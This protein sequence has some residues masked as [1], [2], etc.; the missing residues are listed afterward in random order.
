MI[1]LT[2]VGSV[3]DFIPASRALGIGRRDFRGYDRLTLDVYHQKVGT[4]TISYQL[5]NETA[6]AP[7]LD[8]GGAEVVVSDAQA[9]AARFLT[10]TFTVNRADVILLRLRSK[11]TVAGD[12]P[13]FLGASVLL[14]KA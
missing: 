9:A 4:G 1:P 2:N 11:S 6:G 7:L 5:W 8:A 12:D 13:V 10:A 14:W 3:Y